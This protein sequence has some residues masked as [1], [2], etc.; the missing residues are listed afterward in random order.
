MRCPN[1]Q[2]PRI[3]ADLEEGETEDGRASYG[4]W[5][6]QCS[7]GQRSS[8]WL[9]GVRGGEAATVSKNRERTTRAG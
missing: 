5:F 6:M 4:T 7:E 8:Q 3:V 1:L 2:R 9:S